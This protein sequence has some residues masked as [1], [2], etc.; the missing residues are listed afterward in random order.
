LSSKIK[1]VLSLV[2]VIVALDQATKL[3]VDRTL[4]LHESIPIIEGF[5]N[6]TYIRNTGAAFGIFAG[7]H[8]AFRQPFLILFSILAIGF[9]LVMLRRLPEG[10]RSLLVALSF[11]LG[12]AVGN[13]IDRFLYGEVI[14][15]LDFYWSRFHWPAFN[16]A[17]SFITV[18]VTL[19]LYR[20]IRA[21]GEDPF[22][23]PER[24]SL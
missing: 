9:I 17:D 16:L 5:F 20:L 22:G 21:K 4:S 19:T 12:G 15:F 18:G 7:S 13:L 8:A 3:I 11:I 1:L 10:E 24:K 2:V 23:I 6:L 14:D